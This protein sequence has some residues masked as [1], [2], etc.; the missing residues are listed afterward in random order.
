MGEGRYPVQCFNSRI[1]VFTHGLQI[2]D[3]IFS[4]IKAIIK[5]NEQTPLKKSIQII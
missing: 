5:N 4:A 3:L 2:N 1:P